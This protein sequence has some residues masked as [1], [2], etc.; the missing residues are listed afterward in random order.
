MPPGDCG[1][2]L[3]KHFEQQTQGNIYWGGLTIATCWP[4]LHTSGLLSLKTQKDNLASTPTTWTARSHSLH[5]FML[6]SKNEWLFWGF[7]FFHKQYYW[8]FCSLPFEVFPK[9]VFQCSTYIPMMGRNNTGGY[10]GKDKDRL[11]NNQVTTPK[12]LLLFVCLFGD[13]GGGFVFCLAVWILFVCL[14]W[15]GQEKIFA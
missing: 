3:K 14:F 11:L 9:D 15:G 4:I 8:G 2:L 7:F 1:L 13:G 12:A 10:G 5:D 6:H